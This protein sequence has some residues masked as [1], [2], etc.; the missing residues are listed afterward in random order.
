VSFNP[1]DPLG[2]AFQG[3]VAAALADGL[4]DQ[5]ALLA[6]AAGRLGLLWDEARRLVAKGKR[7]RPAFCYWG[8]VATAGQPADPGP[9]LAVAASF[10]LLHAGALVHDDII[11][12][13]DTRRGEPA[14]HRRFAAFHRRQ[15]WAGDSDRFGHDAAIVFGDLLL[16]VAAGLAE[17][18]GVPAVRL[19]QA[20]PYLDAA[21]AEVMAGQY[22]D[23]AAQAQ[24][25]GSGRAEAELV[26]E[27]KTARYTV[28][29]P[30]QTGAAIGGASPG[31]L[32]GLG[33]FGSQLGQAFQLVDD[34][35]GVF[36]DPAVTGKPAG[37]DLRE[38]KR[39]VLVATA[40]ERAAP[41]AASR[42]ASL[43]GR[44][45]LTAAE[46]DDAKSVLVDSGAAAA[47]RQTAQ[48]A[49]AAA[50]ETLDGLDLTA[51]GRTA[52]AALAAAA[53]CR[54]A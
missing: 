14:A 45:S 42:L 36:G 43:L 8:C 47:V 41:A 7:L 1:A 32:A 29:R 31:V 16:A 2:A 21:R 26:T 6:E 17:R 38:G 27:L 46:I 52:L 53:V 50:L 51:P 9:L 54:E 24:G 28:S 4:D 18:S 40:L 15:G 22:L 33:R 35:L 34:L 11:D 10:D 3:A 5:A 30:V 19:G 44:P 20:R 13:S 37:D 25:A 12:R 23:L 39:T 49:A 48:A